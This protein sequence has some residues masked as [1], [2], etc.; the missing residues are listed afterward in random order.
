MCSKYVWGRGRAG[1][2]RRGGGGA[3][4]TSDW[5]TVEQTH[6]LSV[7]HTIIH[8]PVSH[9]SPFPHEQ[10]ISQD[11]SLAQT[12]LL[13]TQRGKVLET[14]LA[15]TGGDKCSFAQTTTGLAYFKWGFRRSARPLLV[16][17]G[18]CF[19]F[20]DDAEGFAAMKVCAGPGTNR[21]I[22]HHLLQLA[23]YYAPRCLQSWR[24][25]LSDE[26]CVDIHYRPAH[27]LPVKGL[28][29]QVEF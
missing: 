19:G 15:W 6:H 26:G 7:H 5:T 4:Q 3:E 27:G 1:V 24:R 12:E 28:S 25:T 18:P 9:H 20:S 8:S 14:K 21:T 10:A 22:R 17:L 16:S 11:S 23:R 13:H 2:V 29:V